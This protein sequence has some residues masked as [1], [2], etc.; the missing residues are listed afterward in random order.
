[1]KKHGQKEGLTVMMSRI[2]S[3][4]WTLS[5]GNT[6][7]TTGSVPSWKR[8]NRT[9]HEQKK[10]STASERA[11]RKPFPSVIRRQS[12]FQPSDEAQLTSRFRRTRTSNRWSRGPW[13]PALFSENSSQETGSGAD[14]HRSMKPEG[15]RGADAALL[16]VTLHLS[17]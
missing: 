8:Q 4:L 3:R 6:S 1:M 2:L 9:G 16:Q 15:G 17:V 5:P 10:C 13:V 7:F 14:S 12:V 11:A